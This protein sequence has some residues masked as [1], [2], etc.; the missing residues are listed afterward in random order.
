[1]KQMAFLVTKKNVNNM[2]CIAKVDDE[3]DDSD[4][5]ADDLAD[6]E[7]LDSR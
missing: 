3:C 7:E 4:E 2:I 6:F 1:M 5:V